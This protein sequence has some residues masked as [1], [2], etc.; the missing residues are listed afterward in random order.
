MSG[1][2]VRAIAA[3]MDSIEETVKETPGGVPGGILYAALMGL[4]LTFSTFEAIM[5]A[6]VSERKLVKRGQLYFHT[7][8]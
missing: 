3:I 5:Q 8:G 7:G 2:V 4:G 1:D 6:L